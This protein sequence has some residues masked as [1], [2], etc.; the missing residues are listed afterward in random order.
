MTKC[1]IEFY[2]HEGTE[3]TVYR[4]EVLA[5]NLSEEEHKQIREFIEQ[6]GGNFTRIDFDSIS[7]EFIIEQYSEA[8]KL[9]KELE[10]DGWR[11][12]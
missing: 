10:K 9:L 1:I 11:W 4:I 2:K 8:I 6:H 5:Y 3:K 12:S 7:A